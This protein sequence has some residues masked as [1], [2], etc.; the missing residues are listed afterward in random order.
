MNDLWHICMNESRHASCCMLTLDR[1][2]DMNSPEDI[3]VYTRC[4]RQQHTHSLWIKSEATTTG[5]VSISINAT[6]QQHTSTHC[7]PLQHTATHYNI[8]PYTATHSHTL[9][10]ERSNNHRARFNR[11]WRHTR[12]Q[13]HMDKRAKG[14]ARYL[15]KFIFDCYDCSQISLW[16]NSLS[17]LTAMRR[18]VRA[19]STRGYKCWNE[20]CDVHIA[21]VYVCI[22]IYIYIYMHM[23]ALVYIYIYMCIRCVYVYIYTYA[24]MHVYI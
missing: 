22:Y 14:I 1:R 16:T 3:P 4:N 7:N 20:L 24:Y 9:D 10:Q 11:R 19:S 13:S 2:W 18:V 12:L 17:K 23:C 15:E 6:T 8:L 21:C 5:P